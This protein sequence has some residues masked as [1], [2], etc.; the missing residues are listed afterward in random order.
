MVVSV[1]SYGYVLGSFAASL[2]NT[3]CTYSAFKEKVSAI[4]MYLKVKTFISNFLIKYLNIYLIGQ[5][6]GFVNCKKSYKVTI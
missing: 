2:T 3:N 1:I 6:S 5:Q 4:K